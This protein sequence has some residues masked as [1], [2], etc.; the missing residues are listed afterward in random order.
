[1]AQLSAI[2]AFMAMMTASRFRTGSAPG[3]PRHTG[4]TCVLG[5]SPKRVEQE[6]KILDLVRS[7][8]CTSRPITASYLAQTSVATDIFPLEPQ[9]FIILY[10]CRDTGVRC[11]SIGVG[12]RTADHTRLY[13]LGAL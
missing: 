5:G 13:A 4:Q 12:G 7:W 10:R 9:A 11:R 6:Q 3:K 2:A 1:M 8:T